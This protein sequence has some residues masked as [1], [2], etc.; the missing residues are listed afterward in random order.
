MNKPEIYIDGLNV[1]MR[2][3]AA[4]PA[5]SIN[6]QLCGGI[7]GMLKNIQH[8]SERFSP[9]KIVIVWEGGGSVRRKSIDPNYKNL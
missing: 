9:Q 7:V 3:F 6:G 5:K 1:F 8:L 2:H 4:N